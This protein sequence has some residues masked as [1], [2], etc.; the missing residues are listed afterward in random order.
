MYIGGSSCTLF[1]FRRKHLH[2]IITE[3]GLDIHEYFGTTCAFQS[4]CVHKQEITVLRSHSVTCVT[5]KVIAGVLFQ[6]V[7]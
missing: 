3:C 6:H 2:T 5:T 1:N 7:N 4:I